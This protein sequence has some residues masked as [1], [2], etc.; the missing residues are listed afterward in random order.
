M[1]SNL[2][3]PKRAAAPIQ[4]LCHLNGEQ[5]SKHKPEMPRRNRDAPVVHCCRVDLGHGRQ[6]DDDPAQ[7]LARLRCALDRDQLV[8]LQRIAHRL[9]VERQSESVGDA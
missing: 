1:R 7:V 3:T 8:L 4:T 5:A 9:H 6:V 2:H